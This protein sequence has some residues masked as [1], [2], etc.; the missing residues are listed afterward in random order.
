MLITA[1]ILGFIWSSIISHWGASILLHRYYCHRQFEVPVWF[2]IVGLYMLSVAYVRSPI[3]WI[4]SHRMHH[5]HTDTE[6]D[7][8]SPI[9]LGFWKVFTTTWDVPKIP[10]KYAKDLFQNSR[11]IFVHNHHIKILIAHWVISFLISP[12]LF[13]GY[14]LIPFVHAKLGFGLINT[15]GHSNGPSNAP[16]INLLVAGEGYHKNHHDNW[17]RIRLAKF[18]SSGW[19]IERLIQY[20]IFKPKITN[21]IS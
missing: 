9:H 13:L 15:M 3:G 20:G 5:V 14:A 11:L 1:I 19:I 17:K 10:V 16:W 18:D 2:E 6:H 8:H 7:P 4:A 12:Y 21:S